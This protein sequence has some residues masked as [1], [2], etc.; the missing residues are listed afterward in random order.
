MAGLNDICCRLPRFQSQT[1]K[2]DKRLAAREARQKAA[3]YSSPYC[4]FSFA[5]TNTTVTLLLQTA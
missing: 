1:R 5:T 3:A 2:D 4:S